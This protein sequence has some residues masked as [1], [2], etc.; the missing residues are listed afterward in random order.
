MMGYYG[1]YAESA[2]QVIIVLGVRA[3]CAL[4]VEFH[5][6]RLGYILYLYVLTRAPTNR[7][8]SSIS[9]KSH[10]IVGVTQFQLM[11]LCLSMGS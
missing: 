6:Q 1:G 9:R 3:V 8:I 10:Q 7:I 11:L 5:M 2:F 4:S